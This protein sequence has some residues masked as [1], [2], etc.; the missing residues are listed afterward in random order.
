MRLKAEQFHNRFLK[1]QFDTATLII[2]SIKMIKARGCN[3]RFKFD[4]L[5]N[6]LAPGWIR[7]YMQYYYTVI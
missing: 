3:Q 7:I 6:Y 1:L 5:R 4:L 2:Q